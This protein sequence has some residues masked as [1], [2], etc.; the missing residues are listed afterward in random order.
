MRFAVFIR[1]PCKN[2]AKKE[3]KKYTGKKLK[4]KKQFFELSTD[5]PLDVCKLCYFSRAIQRI[6]I[7]FDEKEK[8]F[9]EKDLKIKKIDN[10]VYVDFSSDLE[11]RGYV[12]KDNPPNLSSCIAFLAVNEIQFNRKDILVDP[13]CR[14]GKFL[15]EA[16]HFINNIPAGRFKKF[17]F[18]HLK[19]FER[20]DFQKIFVKWDNKGIEQDLKI[21]GIDSYTGNIDNAKINLESANVNAKLSCRSI[22]WM[23]SLFE[24]GSVDKIVT[25][26]PSGKHKSTEALY[27]ELFYQSVYCLNKKGMMIILSELENLVKKYAGQTGFKIVKVIQ[28]NEMKL[29]K[30]KRL[31]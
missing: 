19:L 8:N 30:I 14:G 27:R 26:L 10:E 22:D 15:I 23:D 20:Y 2:L 1:K 9:T 7:K 6:L 24:E 29:F 28:L 13:L 5:R 25:M 4:K 16:A 12:I 21:F 3:V 31:S 17:P 18:V 11:K